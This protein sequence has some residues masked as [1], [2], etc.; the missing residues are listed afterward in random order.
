MKKTKAFSLI[1]ALVATVIG[2]ISILAI[3][4]SYIFFNN[5][6]QKITDKAK[7]SASGRSSLQMIAKDLR[8]AGYKNMNYEAATGQTWD[9]WIEKID[10]FDGNKGDKLRIWYNTSARDR[11]EV[12]YFLKKDSSGDTYLVRESIEN[13]VRNPMRMNCQRFDTQK[14][15]EP[16]TI[17]SKA[18]DFQVFFN[19]QNGNRVNNV[20]V[21]SDNQS[22]V[23][24]AE[25]YITVRSP[26]ELL[27]N[28]IS[29]E[30]LN[31][32][33]AGN[34]TK[35]DKYLRETF[36]ISVYLRNVVKL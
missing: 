11:I 5:S 9:R 31:G 4:Y 32:G 22:K 30:M 10:D 8:N 23:H 35:R 3:T 13:P 34:F 20:N 24:T 18:T 36:Y 21:G 2:A 15:C 16:I 26:N 17:V 1:E 19:D 12:Q 27:K 29:F 33:T 25:V 7:M 14:N 28:P 6:Y